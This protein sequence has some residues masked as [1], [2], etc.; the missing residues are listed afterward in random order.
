[1][2][3]NYESE[4]FNLDSCQMDL[5][6]FRFIYKSSFNYILFQ[7]E[8]FLLC[9]GFLMGCSSRGESDVCLEDMTSAEVVIETVL[10]ESSKQGTEKFFDLSNI[11]VY[12]GGAYVVINKN[13]PYFTTYEYS[14]LSFESYSLLDNLGRCGVAYANIGKDI[15]PTEE[16]GSIGMVKPTGWHTVR[17]ENVDGKYLYNRCH[18]IGYQLSGENANEQ[19]LITGTRYMNIT[20]MQPFENMVADYVQETGNHVL[21]R[22]TPIFDGN[23]LLATGVLMEAL[24]MEDG[25][26]GVCFNVF[27]YNVQPGIKIDY[28]TGESQSEY[29]KESYITSSPVAGNTNFDSVTNYIANKNTKKF[30]YPDCKSVAQMK[31]KNKEYLNCTRDEVINQGYVPCKSCNP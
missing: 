14:T 4:N 11:P 1:M 19:N 22:V 20:G 13:Q 25:G 5:K 18:L 8:V 24:S 21:Y 29:G 26:V 12:T 17:Y 28:A 15:M 10:P 16:R 30:H 3:R 6:K 9:L 7:A 27:C 23:N 31:E 2:K